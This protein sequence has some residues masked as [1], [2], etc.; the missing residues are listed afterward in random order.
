M[1]CSKTRQN[2]TDGKP[3]EVVSL[4]SAISFFVFI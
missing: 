3:G 1:T 4:G 2:K